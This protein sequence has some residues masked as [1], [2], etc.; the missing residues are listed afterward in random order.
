M[1]TFDRL[2]VGLDTVATSWRPSTL[3]ASD[4]YF[5]RPK[6]MRRVA[7]RPTSSA[8]THGPEPSSAGDKYSTVCES[9]AVGYRTSLS[10]L[11]IRCGSPPEG[12]MRHKSMSRVARTP[13]TK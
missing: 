4:T 2:A 9:I 5:S 1:G 12:A 10:W 3:D 7:R 6:L 13:E 11:V 8:H